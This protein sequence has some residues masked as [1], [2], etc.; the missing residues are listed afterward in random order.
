MMEI[1]SVDNVDKSVDNLIFLYLNLWS[2][3]FLAK[4]IKIW[5]NTLNLKIKLHKNYPQDGCK[6]LK[7][8]EV[9]G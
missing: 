7:N 8:K 9:R 6:R 3:F 1:K 2:I 4:I 5:Y